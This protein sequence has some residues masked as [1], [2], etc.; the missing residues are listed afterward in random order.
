MSQKEGHDDVMMISE[1]EL[2]TNECMHFR[3]FPLSIKKCD[4]L[5]PIRHSIPGTEQGADEIEVIKCVNQQR[6]RDL[7]RGPRGNFSRNLNQQHT[8]VY[9]YSGD[10]TII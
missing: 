7:S 5:P 6:K 8:Y 4:M 1:E 2:K 9:T 3:I 10:Y